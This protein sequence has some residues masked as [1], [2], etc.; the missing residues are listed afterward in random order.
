MGTPFAAGDS[1]SQPL[2]EAFATFPEARFNLEIKTA[3]PRAVRA[4]LDLVER[5]DCSARTLLAAEQDPIMKEIR[6]M[7]TV[8]PA[9]PARSACVGEVVA[10]VRSAVS[11]EPM[12]PGVMALQVPPSFMGESLVTRELVDHVH[13]RGVEV[14]VWTIN[15]IPEIERLLEIG[16][17]GIVTDYPGRM[18]HWLEDAGRV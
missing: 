11:G 3:D 2:E 16:V 14:H 1:R 4:T 7:L 13:A 17:D 12:P 6:E 18:T 10:A 9:A 8:H 15:E 5:F